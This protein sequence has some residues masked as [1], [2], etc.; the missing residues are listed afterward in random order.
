M[1]SAL[2][3]LGR[4]VWRRLNAGAGTATLRQCDW[5]FLLP[6]PA[7]GTFEH[8]VLLG[9]PRGLAETIVQAEIARRVSQTVPAE[10]DADALIVL[11]RSNVSIATASR[12]LRPDGVV[13]WEIDRRRP[14]RWLTS[15]GWAFRALRSAELSPMSAYWVRPGF[16]EAQVYLPLGD[17]SLLR[18]YLRNNYTAATA[19]EIVMEILLRL[20]GALGVNLRE[21]LIPAFALTA[22]VNRGRM[23]ASILG[24]PDVHRDLWR[25]VRRP[26]GSGR[27]SDLELL[28]LTG[29]RDDWNRIIAMPFPVGG[30][31]PLAVLKL[32]RVSGRNVHTEREQ[33]VLRNIRPAVDSEMRRSL[34]E[35]FGTFTWQG[36]TVGM[37]SYLSGRLLAATSARWGYSL[38]RKIDDLN[39]AVQWLI[40]FHRQTEMRRARW[41]EEELAEWSMRPLERYE[42][43][44]GLT[45]TE[46]K[47]F[48]K[49][50]ERY[51]ALAGTTFPIVWYHYAFSAWN[52]CRENKEI[53]AFDWESAERGPALLD[54][55]YLVFR[56]NQELGRSRSRGGTLRAFREL[57]L[58]Q[59]NGHPAIRAIH[60]A[61]ER[62]FDALD[63][64]ARAFPVALVSL[65]AQHANTRALRARSLDG[66]GTDV[67]RGNT[68]VAC[69]DVLAQHAETL[70]RVW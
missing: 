3:N 59:A 37:E 14:R 49:T 18:W 69:L 66:P 65:W 70:F 30:T 4:R 13:Y 39:L 56:W 5:R 26:R 27:L 23:A 53:G 19:S 60:K 28:L 46:K 29:G 41:G 22:S 12:C 55:I 20:L 68:Y 43:L 58:T 6:T 2:P 11:R 50:R 47:L 57:F 8:L 45:A 67:R 42:E 61:I 1:L 35:A 36:L 17:D 40:E 31:N 10:A 38:S 7:S 48:E 16:S 52:I 64:D 44:F 51:W 33:Q 9:A 15:V 63:I 62:Y 25:S 54:L 21:R 34:P 32:S 24:H